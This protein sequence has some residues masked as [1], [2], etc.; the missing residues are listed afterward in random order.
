MPATV[1]SNILDKTDAYLDNHCAMQSSTQ[2][3]KY[4]TNIMLR[5]CWLPW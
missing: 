2:S 1:C 3:V 4:E 5:I